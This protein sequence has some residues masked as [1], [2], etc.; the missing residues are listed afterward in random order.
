MSV[1]QI[2]AGIIPGSGATVRQG[3][4]DK[5]LHQ[6][7]RVLNPTG[8]FMEFRLGFRA[9]FPHRAPGHELQR[10]RG[11][12]HGAPDIME[13]EH[14][15]LVS[16]IAAPGNGRRPLDRLEVH[17][18]PVLQAVATRRHNSGGLSGIRR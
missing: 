5:I 4:A 16:L 6:M 13:Y 14:Q 18:L 9:H 1:A 12:D 15:L 8:D 11:G 7:N 17:H 10:R 3:L 2:E